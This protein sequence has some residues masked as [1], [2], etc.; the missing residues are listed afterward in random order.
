MSPNLFLYPVSDKRKAFTRIAQGNVVHPTTKDRVHLLDHP[1]HRLADILSEDLLQL[2]HQRRPFLQLRRVVRSPLPVTTPRH[3]PGSAGGRPTRESPRIDNPSVRQ[4]QLDVMKI[5]AIH[6]TIMRTLHAEEEA[7]QRRSK[8]RFRR[9]KA[10]TLFGEPVIDPLGHLSA[11]YPFPA[12]LNE[13]YLAKLRA[14][15]I[16]T[17]FSKEAILYEEGEKTAGVY[18]VLEGRVKLSVNSA[19]GKRLVLG[20]FGPGT[21]LGLA[22][23]ILGRTHP[24]T[25]EVQTPTKVLFVP[26]LELV[27]EMLGDATVARQAAQ[28]VS[29]TCY[30]ILGKMR[31]VDL[32]KSAVQKLARC[33]LG[34]LDQNP[35]SSEGAAPKLGLSQETL[36]QMVGLSRETVTRLLSRLR[37]RYV[38]DWKRSG[39][40]IRDRSALERLADFSE[41]DRSEERG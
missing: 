23:P 17:S 39:L 12:R 28:L 33:L 4:S 20:I 5:T 41:D 40:V 31:A 7:M 22:A 19:Q 32:S 9:R 38:V 6:G 10:G 8:Q 13:H 29:E 26:R 24:T 25:A 30:F 15:N 2:C 36:A 14:T 1:L 27:R 37:R 11:R 34:L 21:I 35:S 18:V 16:G 3:W